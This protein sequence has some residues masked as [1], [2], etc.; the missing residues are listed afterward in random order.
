MKPEGS[1]PQSQM[2]ATCPY[3]GPARYSPYPQTYIWKIHH[4]IN[5]I[6]TWV[7]LAVSFPQISPPENRIQLSSQ[8]YA[9]HAPPISFFSI[10]SPETYWLSSTDYSAPHYAASPLPSYLVPLTPNILL[11][12]LF[13]NTLSRRSYLNVSDQVSHLYKLYSCIT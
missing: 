7:S 1:L 8:P 4:N 6:Y 13:S 5:P 11:N 2:P 12:T 10:L 9:L 3:P